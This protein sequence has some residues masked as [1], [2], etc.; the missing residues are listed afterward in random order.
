[1][2][3]RKAARMHRT[4]YVGGHYRTSSKGKIYWVN[5]HMRNDYGGPVLP[6]RRTIMLILLIAGPFT[7]GFTWVVMTVGCVIWLLEG[8]R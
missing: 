7:F 5:G 2:G 4:Q 8:K 6:R 1:M 3:Y